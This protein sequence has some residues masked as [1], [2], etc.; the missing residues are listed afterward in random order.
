MGTKNIFLCCFC[1]ILSVFF[2]TISGKCAVEIISLENFSHHSHVETSD[3]SDEHSSCICCLTLTAVL[4]TTRDAHLYFLDS[5]RD[6][7]SNIHYFYPRQSI[8]Y[9]DLYITFSN[10]QFYISVFSNH[11]PPITSS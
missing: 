10:T 2:F 4:N 11:A 8:A 6:E 5:Q 9:L 3:N 1:L 7:L